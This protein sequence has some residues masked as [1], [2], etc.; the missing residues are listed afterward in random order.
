MLL[1]DEPT[2]E[3]DAANRANVVGLL[4]RAEAAGGAVVVMA[5]HDPEAAAVCDGEVR[6]DVGRLTRLR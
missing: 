6:L 5:T 1:A 2:S 4:L 3:L